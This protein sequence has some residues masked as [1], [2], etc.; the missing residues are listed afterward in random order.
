[1]AALEDFKLIKQ[2]SETGG[3]LNVLGP[4]DQKKYEQLVQ[5]GWLKRSA[6]AQSASARYQ[7][8]ERGKA[9]AERF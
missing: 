3:Q 9:A 7:I 2:V 4:R 6:S 5:L 8:T 1:M